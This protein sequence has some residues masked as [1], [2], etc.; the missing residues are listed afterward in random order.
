FT[1]LLLLVCGA[2]EL[3]LPTLCEWHPL[4]SLSGGTS[5]NGNWATIRIQNRTVYGGDP[6]R[7]PLPQ[8]NSRISD[9]IIKQMQIVNLRIS[10][11]VVDEGPADRITGLKP[12][13]SALAM[14]NFRSSMFGMLPKEIGRCKKGDEKSSGMSLNWILIGRAGASSRGSRELKN[15]S[16]GD[17]GAGAENK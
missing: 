16:G 6:A 5:D 13:I 12:E 11:Q 10:R 1:A 14:R 7:S 15:C 9:Q 8:L 2:S 17:G 3:Q 4:V